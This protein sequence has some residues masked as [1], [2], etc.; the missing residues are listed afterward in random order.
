MQVQIES[1]CIRC[2]KTR[3]IGKVW[4]EKT[5]KG[6]PITHTETICPDSECQKKVDA[7]FAAKRERKLRFEKK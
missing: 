6:N 3:V 2:G 4:V 1:S 7:D 5:D